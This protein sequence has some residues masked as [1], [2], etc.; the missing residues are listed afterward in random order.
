MGGCDASNTNWQSYLS[1]VRYEADKRQL[2]P[3]WIKPSDSE[4]PPLLVYKWC[5]GINNLT[6]VWETDNGECVVLMQ[7]TLERMYEKLD[8][9]LINR[10]LRLIVD[11][12]IADYVTGKNNVV[13]A[14]KDMM[15]TNNYGLIRGLQFASFVMQVSCCNAVGGG[16]LMIWKF[17]AL[18]DSIRSIWPII[19]VVLHSQRSD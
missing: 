3:N 13:I 2:F 11:Q 5:H 15:H 16:T 14:Y 10:L 4:P 9:T 18:C 19:A 1:P 8:L 6:N 12:N 17:W 7:S